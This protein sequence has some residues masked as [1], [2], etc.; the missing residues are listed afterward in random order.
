MYRFPFAPFQY[1]FIFLFLVYLNN[2]TDKIMFMLNEKIG[3]LET[4]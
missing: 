3:A 1:F 2:E 4:R